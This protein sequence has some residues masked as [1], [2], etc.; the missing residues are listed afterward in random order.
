MPNARFLQAMEGAVR[1]TASSLKDPF[2]T[3]C[4]TAVGAAKAVAKR[5]KMRDCEKY[6][7]KDGILRMID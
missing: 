1:R 4:S 7:V 3:S 5:L 2:L 6:M